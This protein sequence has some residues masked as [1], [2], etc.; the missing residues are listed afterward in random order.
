VL[1]LLAGLSIFAAL[2]ALFTGRGVLAFGIGAA[3]MGAAMALLPALA[4]FRSAGTAPGF[5]PLARVVIFAG[6][7]LLIALCVPGILAAF[8]AKHS[9]DDAN[10]S[11]RLGLTAARAGDS[12]SALTSFKQAR[13]AFADARKRLG[14]PV[15]SLSLVVPMVGSNLRAAL[16]VAK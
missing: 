14:S 1:G 2:L 3:L 6:V 7:L 9:F 8:D 15:S 4:G 16:D 13:V 10:E 12:L 5:S 11:V